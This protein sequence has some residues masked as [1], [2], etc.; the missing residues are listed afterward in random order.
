MCAHIQGSYRNPINVWRD[1]DVD[2]GVLIHTSMLFAKARYVSFTNNPWGNPFNEVCL[3]SYRN[4][5]V[6]NFVSE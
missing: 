4:R 6:N 5:L 3:C 2:M 1:R